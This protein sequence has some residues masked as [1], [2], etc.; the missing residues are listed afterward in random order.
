MTNEE[1]KLLLRA[2]RSTG[3]DADDPRIREALEQAKRDPALARWFQ[4]EQA[5]TEIIGRKIK[6]ATPVPPDL[7]QGILTMRNVSK[8]RPWAKRIWRYAAAAVFVGLLAA[9]ALWLVR[10]PQPS[11]LSFQNAMAQRAG[12]KTEHIALHTNDLLAIRAWL[13]AHDGDSAA[14]LP[15]ALESRT[16]AGCEVLKWNGLSVSLIC[17]WKTG[18]QHVD[19]FVV[20]SPQLAR[21]T[22]D[23]PIARM[24]GERATLTWRS[25]E[26]VFLLAARQPESELQKLL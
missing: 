20:K 15:T 18:E 5:A 24:F 1:A 23:K 11:L 25:G 8:P 7:L 16:A 12:I 26:R 14:A 4:E 10:S 3:A 22:G 6:G 2:Y 17:F 19:L 9:A 13:A 21:S